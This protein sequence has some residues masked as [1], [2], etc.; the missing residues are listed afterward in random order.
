[1]TR[2]RRLIVISFVVLLTC[3]SA[4][5]SESFYSEAPPQG[6][7]ERWMA[8][9]AFYDQVRTART[10]SDAEMLGAFAAD[11]GLSRRQLEMALS[12]GDGLL[13]QLKSIDDESRARLLSLH[14]APR[15]TNLPRREDRPALTTAPLVVKLPHGVKSVRELAVNTGLFAQAEA[16]KDAVVQN[17]L[18]GLDR[19]I[20]GDGR[21]ALEQWVAAHIA[22]Q[23]VDSVARGKEPDR[24]QL[25]HGNRIAFNR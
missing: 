23:R 19:L 1:M 9:R 18:R 22:V 8:W 3:A 16:R 12:E 2:V 11:I 17:H 20:G 21:Q 6:T 14:G 10:A 15:P 25:R 13:L 5:K 4:H 7:A 24:S